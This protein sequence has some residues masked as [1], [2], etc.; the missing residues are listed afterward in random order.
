MPLFGVGSTFN[1]QL[2]ED[3]LVNQLTFQLINLLTY[4]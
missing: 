4:N 3:Y 1:V 2:P